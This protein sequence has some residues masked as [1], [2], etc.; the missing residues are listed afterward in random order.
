MGSG[1]FCNYYTGK[2]V[3]HDQVPG[4][5]GFINGQS[6]WKIMPPEKERAGRAAYGETFM[7]KA[8]CVHGRFDYKIS[9]DFRHRRD[10]LDPSN[11]FAQSKIQGQTCE[12]FVDRRPRLDR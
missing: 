3:P 8:G 12:N 1:N 9:P 5:R 10:Q 11:V 7:Q 6:V 4:D 2:C